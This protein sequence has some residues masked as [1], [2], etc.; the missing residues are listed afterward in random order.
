MNPQQ[1]PNQVPTPPQPPTT[2]TPTPAAAPAPTPAP[3]QQQPPQETPVFNPFQPDPT[4]AQ[5]PNQVPPSYTATPAPTPAPIPPA[6]LK[7]KRKLFIILGAVGAG[8]ILLVVAALFVIDSF[9][10]S[11]EDYQAAAK[12]YSVVSATNTLLASS[13]YDLTS[14]DTTSEFDAAAKKTE[15]NF[16]KLE[17]E[18]QTLGGLK[19]SRVGESGKLYGEFDKK[20]DAYIAYAK[21]VFESTKKFYPA[22]V[23]C[24][25]ISEAEDS[26]ARVIAVK[27]CSDALSSVG[28]LPEPSYDTYAKALAT[29][30]AQYSVVLA[31]INA[32]SDPYG[33][34]YEQYKTLRDKRTAIQ[35]SI[36]DAST[37]RREAVNAKEEEL[38]VQDTASA[39]SNYVVEHS[40]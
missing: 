11:K 1:E 17:K 4:A 25:A 3:T 14:S 35:N 39:Y 19:A 13:M 22:S 16:D 38:S 28:D 32:L 27:T 15:E 30:Y 36:S 40:I 31:D 33:S 37:A 34:Q 29:N 12:Q 26:N 7:T 24:D 23:T 21:S 18:N 9:T 6:P 5:Q 20:L 8:L 10:V 2:P